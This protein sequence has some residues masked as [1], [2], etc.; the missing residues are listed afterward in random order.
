ML[1]TFTKQYI[2]TAL[3][4]SNDESTPEGGDPMDKNYSIEDIGPE[5]LAKMVADCAKF[6]ADNAEDIA[7]DLSRAGHDFWL[8]RNGHG[9]GF[10]DGDWPEAGDRLTEACKAYGEVTLYV[11]DDGK[12][13]A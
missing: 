2:I 6:Q 10:W 3:W 4:S 7:S 8:T 5:T 11:G 9:A 1:D 13:Y 12:V